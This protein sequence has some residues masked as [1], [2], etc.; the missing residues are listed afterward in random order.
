M[1]VG[2][3][4]LAVVATLLAVLAGGLFL[5]L[6]ADG[7]DTRV[8]EAGSASAVSPNARERGSSLLSALAPLL[9]A[10]RP[11]ADAPDRN[12]ANASETGSAGQPSSSRST[13]SSD[14]GLGLPIDRAVARLFMV[15]FP[16]ATPDA[17]F[18]ERLLVRDWGA[19]LLT[20]G[21]YSDPT[22]LAT[23]TAQ[24]GVVARNAGHG[25][26]LVAARQ[27]G[28]EDSA[29][30]DLP[31]TAQV[32]QTTNESARGQARLAGKALREAGVTM[33]LAPDADLSAIGGPWD[34]RAFSADAT[35]V[36]RRVQAALAGYRAARVIATVG[37][38]PGEGAA[39]G[40]PS[41][42]S[43]TVGLG[44]DELKAADLRPFDA[45]A[46]SAPVVQ[47]SGALYAA[48]DGVTPATLLPDAVGLLRGPLRFRG[49]VLSADL[50][51]A[52]FTS[53][54]TPGD[55]AVDAL[56]AGCDLLLLPGDAEDQEQAVRTVVRAI[57][58]GTLKVARVREALDRVAALKRR[59]A[60]R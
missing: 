31:P 30:P 13:D 8:P 52:A 25:V 46:S 45:V 17:A 9:G 14:R 22:Q 44:L 40:D 60:V 54:M 56:N 7:D 12:D 43:A 42:V 50:G 53:G 28:G 11:S 4:Q 32:D 23:L 36:G 16:G 1:S 41:A 6:R 49:A 18:F 2:R 48:Y 20:S 51:A 29:F 55:A 38:F 24:I 39:S 35:V 47:M 34:G 10:G 58:R 19:V 59:Y 15:G 27:A 33:T 3:R 21:N 26:P 37:H 5:A 57:R